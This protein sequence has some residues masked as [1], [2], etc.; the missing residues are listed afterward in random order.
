MKIK[1]LTLLLSLVMISSLLTGCLDFSEESIA[2]GVSQDKEESKISEELP[3]EEEEDD[4]RNELEDMIQDSSSLAVLVNKEYSLDE[5]YEPD[6]LVTV[7]V[8]TVLENPEVKQL[9]EEAA[10][11]LKEMFQSA[12]ESDI[13]LHARSGYRSY[14]T[15]VQL[16]NNYVSNHGE[17][18][19]NKFSARPGESEHQTGLAMDITSESVNFQLSK[20]FGQVAEGIWVGENAHRFGFIIRYPEGKEGITGYMYEPWHLRYLGEDLATDVYESGLTYEEYL[21]KLGII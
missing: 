12:K 16:F 21:T 2:E 3:D 11:K 18:A 14:D 4:S 17:E 7:E 19:A 13:I 15:Q 5:D 20:D 6:N 8:P 10:N 9:K 1:L